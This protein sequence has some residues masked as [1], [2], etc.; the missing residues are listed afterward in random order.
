MVDIVVKEAR[1]PLLEIQ[2]NIQFIPNNYDLKGKSENGENVVIITGPNMGGKST[3]MRQVLFFVL[4]LHVV[5]YFD[6]VIA[7]WLFCS[8]GF[9]RIPSLHCLIYSYWSIG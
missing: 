3:Y 2:S 7:N 1:H 5:G 6:C 4:F 8:C 9:C